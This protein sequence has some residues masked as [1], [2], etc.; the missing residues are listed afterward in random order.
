MLTIA[1]RL[2][3]VMDY[4]KIIVMDKG[5]AAEQGSPQELLN[6][7]NGIFLAMVNATGPNSAA[8]LKLMVK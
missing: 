1:H 7:E 3:T 6:D 5:K 8:Q 4:D 2:E